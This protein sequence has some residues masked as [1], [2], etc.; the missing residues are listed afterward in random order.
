MYPKLCNHRFTK[1]DIV[2]ITSSIF[3]PLGI[4]SPVHK[5]AKTFIQKLWSRDIG[6]DQPIPN[7]LVETWSELSHELNAATKTWIR[8]KYFD[9]VDKSKDSFELHV[10]GDA[11]PESYGA[12]VYLKRG[13]DC[14]LVMS[15]ARVAPVKPITLPRLELM[16]ALIGSRLLRYVYL[17]LKQDFKISRST[18]WSD[19]QIVIHWIKSDKDLPIFVKNRVNEIRKNEVIDSIRYC[20]TAGNPADMLT[21]G[22]TV[23]EFENS[24]LWWAGPHWLSSGE[25]PES[26]VVDDNTVHEDSSVTNTSDINS[27]T[28]T[29]VNAANTTSEVNSTHVIDINRYSSYTRMIRITALVLRFIW[30]IRKRNTETENSRKSRYADKTV[31]R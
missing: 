21:R 12:G 31:L 23:A 11:N 6:W 13:R 25:Y 3:D 15:R 16:A 29:L 20:P 24:S 1:R 26:I 9:S 4:V 10:F 14:K 2:R 30:N 17:S 7:D 28:S 18:L 22:I 19:S 27:V 8:R 5:R